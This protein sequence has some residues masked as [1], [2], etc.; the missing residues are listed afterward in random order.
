MPQ[1]GQGHL[2]SLARWEIFPLMTQMSGASRPVPCVREAC[3][4]RLEVVAAKHPC[5]FRVEGLCTS[6]AAAGS[7]QYP[8][9]CAWGACR[10]AKEVKR[11]EASL[12][13]AR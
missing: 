7:R 8:V 10:Q 4:R 12:P 9:P 3:G 1:A 6:R 2:L 13:V 5:P 11:L